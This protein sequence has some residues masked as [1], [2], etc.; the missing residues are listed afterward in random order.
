MLLSKRN[1]VI[2]FDENSFALSVSLC[3]RWY[4]K[5]IGDSVDGV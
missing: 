4:L 1:V 5:L 3:L 2:L